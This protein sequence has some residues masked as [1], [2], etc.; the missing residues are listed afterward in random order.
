MLE[1]DGGARLVDFLAAG[2]AAFEEVFFDFGVGDGAAGREVREEVGGVCEGSGEAGE[3][4]GE[5]EALEEHC[6]C[7][8]V[9]WLGD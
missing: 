4:E 8:G 6:E 5:G 3:A 9:Y 7:V 2:A 1:L